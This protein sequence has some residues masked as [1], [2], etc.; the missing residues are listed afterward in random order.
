MPFIQQHQIRQIWQAPKACLIATLFVMLPMQGIPSHAQTPQ[1][2][3]LGDLIDVERE[4]WSDPDFK[5]RFIES[6]LSDTD[7]EPALSPQ[8]R[9]L[10]VKV[11]E[12]INT[13]DPMAD[14]EAA[15]EKVQSDEELSDQEKQD[16]IEELREAA[17]EAVEA[18]VQRREELEITFDT[19]G[20]GVDED[21][22]DVALFE[23]QRY[24]DSV[25]LK[26]TISATLY[27]FTA[28][29]HM[30]SAL[31]MQPPEDEDEATQ[32][33]FEA[34]QLMKFD[35]A[36]ADY[37]LAVLRHEKFRRA[38]R[39]LGLLRV[40]LKQYDEARFALSQ[41]VQL[42]RGDSDTYGLLAY[43]F[44]Q[45][46]MHLP[47]ESAYRIANLLDPEE[48]NWKMGLVRS[49]FMQE[50]YAD[51]AAL[52]GEMI[53]AE[54]GNADLWKLQANAYIGLK[55]PMRAAENYQIIDG[56]G[57][58]DVQTMSMLANIYTNEGLHATAVD[59]YLRALDLAKGTDAAAKLED[60]LLRGARVLA[61]QGALEPT[62]RLIVTVNKVMG[63]D[64]TKQEKTQWLKLS[65]R[66]A[67]SEGASD[68]EVKVLEQ[69]VELDPLDGE[70]IILLGKNAARQGDPEKAIL[71]FQRAGLIEK[72]S[73]DAKIDEARVWVK[74]GQYN[75]ALPLLYAVQQENPRENI[76]RFIDDLE[77]INRSN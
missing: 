41:V 5:R 18:R 1:V 20:D 11:F 77:K 37:K 7:L 19:N 55:Q 66:I 25:E 39:N 57:K 42:G 67:V 17:Q 40:R 47:A 23:V 28:N 26:D 29:F 56:L 38:W 73:V 76:A 60:Q 74:Q 65:A 72:F 46:D 58:S 49:F 27:F 68:E 44:S 62:K 36:V 10:L 45:L 63:K 51:V 30:Q 75:K 14:A 31:N 43:C 59:S 12:I 4:I 69:I 22:L 32:A 6:Y 33:E 16:K 48:K 53:K 64:L 50:R 35:R 24:I 9:E 54:P 70:A 15:I 13:E 3:P 71:L 34:Q 61:S 21:P 8:E 2:A 52:A